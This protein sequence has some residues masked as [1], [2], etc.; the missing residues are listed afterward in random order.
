[1]RHTEVG[2]DFRLSFPVALNFPLTLRLGPLRPR[3]FVVEKPIQQEAQLRC[4][5]TLKGTDM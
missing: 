4:L 3:R 2:D 1:M 5:I